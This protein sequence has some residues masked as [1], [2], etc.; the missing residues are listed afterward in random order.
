[1]GGDN[2]ICVGRPDWNS[3]WQCKTSL[4]KKA[5]TDERK[6]KEGKEETGE[7]NAT[8]ER[9]PRN[10][11]QPPLSFIKETKKTRLQHPPSTG[12]NAVLHKTSSPPS[13]F[14]FLLPSQNP[15]STAL[16]L[17]IN[18]L[19]AENNLLPLTRPFSSPHL[20]KQFT[21]TEVAAKWRKRYVNDK[22]IK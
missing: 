9:R 12:Q 15:S 7:N 5:N 13:A 19:P 17:N 11:S 3:E 22:P 10:K 16:L 4:T 6:E 1:M 2:T 21:Q 18:T 8:M 14:F 20:E